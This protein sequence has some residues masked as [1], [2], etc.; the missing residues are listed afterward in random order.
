[1]MRI[2]Q[3]VASVEE[4]ASG[5]SYSILRLCEVLAENHHDVQLLTVGLS[6]YAAVRSSV[7]SIYRQDF[8]GLPG[9]GKLRF[10]RALAAALSHRA[11]EADVVHNHGLWLMPNVECAH[12]AAR[13]Q[14]PLVISPRGTLA[15]AALKFSPHVKRLFWTVLQGPAIRTAS[16]LHATSEQEY[17]D[18]R[19]SGLRQPVSIIPN[20]V[21]LPQIC[22]KPRR[23]NDLR[24][25]LYLGRLHPIKGLDKLL[26]A[27]KDVA[28]GAKDWQMRIVGPDEQGYRGELERLVSDLGVPRVVFAGPRY[29]AEKSNEYAA[30]DLYVLPSHSENFGMSVAEALAHGTPVITTTG[31]PW[32]GLRAHGCGWFVDLSAGALEQALREALS[33]PAD[34]LSTM[35]RAGRNWM[36]CDFAWARIAGQM[37]ETYRWILAG[38]SAPEFVRLK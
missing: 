18:I 15:P 3:V 23:P 21:D 9:L 34:T 28:V 30:A 19:K 26:K 22:T 1:M 37:E 5:P 2:I 24:T 6:K 17:R 31:T 13:H 38:G 27:W 14:K 7:H 8:R 29:G 33:L 20:G 4:E 10:S 25:L 36:R 35:G 32:G 16:C 11:A 12:I